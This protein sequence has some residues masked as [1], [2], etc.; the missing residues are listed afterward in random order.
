MAKLTIVANIKAKADTI[1]L[2]KAA[3]EGAIE[4]FTVNE[5]TR[6]A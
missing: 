1:D 4:D 2:V 6:I 5:M 3:T